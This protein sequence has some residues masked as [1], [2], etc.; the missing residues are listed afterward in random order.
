MFGTNESKDE[1]LD[2][3]LFDFE[4]ISH[5][6]NNISLNNKLGEGGFGPVYKVTML[7]AALSVLSN[8]TA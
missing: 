4:T 5:A 6:T 1:E 8:L 7:T 3:P 2:L